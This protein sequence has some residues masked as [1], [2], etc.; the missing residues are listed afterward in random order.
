MRNPEEA[1]ASLIINQAAI[2]I[3]TELGAFLGQAVRPFNPEVV[4][5]LPT[6]G[7]RYHFKISFHCPC[8]YEIYISP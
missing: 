4:I 5:G 1:V 2:N 3:T 7:L 8:F 6:L